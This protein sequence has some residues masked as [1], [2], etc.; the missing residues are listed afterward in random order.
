MLRSSN[1]PHPTQHFPASPPTEQPV[2]RTAQPVRLQ[3]LFEGAASGAP[4]LGREGSPTAQPVSSLPQEGDDWARDC[5][6][7]GPGPAFPVSAA[8]VEGVQDGVAQS[9]SVEER[10]NQLTNVVQE[11]ARFVTSGVATQSAQLQEGAAQG[12]PAASS[13]DALGTYKLDAPRV[14]L[15]KLRAT[16]AAPMGSGP[17]PDSPSSSSSSGSSSSGGEDKPACRMCG[18]KKHHEKDCPK[19]TAN[20]RGKTLQGVV[21]VAVEVPAVM[22]QTRAHTGM[23]QSAQQLPRRPLQS[24]RKKPSASS[25]LATLPFRPRL[26]TRRKPEDTSTKS[27]WQ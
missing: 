18:S 3:A 8:P 17:P 5:D 11:L 23:Q 20:K 1:R 25:P 15:L 21:Q 14:P 9:P 4:V 7:F 10:M 2:E 16:S 27:S 22:V 24:L 12:A 19:L 26:R 6:L 13:S